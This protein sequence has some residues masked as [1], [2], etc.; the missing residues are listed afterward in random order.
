[1]LAELNGRRWD[2]ARFADSRCCDLVTDSNVH[3]LKPVAIQLFRGNYCKCS[4][5]KTSALISSVHI[6]RYESLVNRD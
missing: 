5:A 1:M 4:T 2:C 3:E 6:R